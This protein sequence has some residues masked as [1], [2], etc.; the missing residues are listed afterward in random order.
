LCERAVLLR[1]GEVA[2]DGSAHD[3]LV[4]YHRLL[5]D[6]RNPDERGA[7]LTEWGGLEARVAEVR[8]EGPDGDERRQFLSGEPLRLHVV[9]AAERPLPAPR[10]SWELRDDSGFLL[11]SGTQD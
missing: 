10:L 2:F 1:E 4:H 8:L 7:G 6:E 5:A 3:A 9:V 11:A